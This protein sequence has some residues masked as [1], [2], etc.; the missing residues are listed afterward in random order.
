MTLQDI[1]KL[2]ESYVR[3]YNPDNIAPFPVEKVADEHDDLD[4]FFT[5]LDD[6]DISGVSLYKDGRFAIIINSGKPDTRQHFTVAH[7]L[8]HYFLHKDLLRKEESIVDGDSW[9]DGPNILY[10][11][12]GEENMRLELEANNFAGSLLMPEELV[13]RAWEVTGDI[14]KCAELFRVSSVAMSVRLTRL[15]LIK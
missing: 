13:R 1:A 7:E 11:V 3:K 9:L 2:A 12:N 5:D 4:I 10:R 8:G 14:E 15:E 6:Y